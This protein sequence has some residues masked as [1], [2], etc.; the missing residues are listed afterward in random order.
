M[1]MEDTEIW[2]SIQEYE[3]YEV[4]IFG[5]VRNKKTGRILKQAITSGYYCVGLSSIKTK[6]YSVHRLVAKSFIP[7]LEN[8][9]QINH[10]DKNRLNNNINN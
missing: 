4:S 10:K 3:N 6:T 2:K 7:N 8:K 5:N 9:E 1:S